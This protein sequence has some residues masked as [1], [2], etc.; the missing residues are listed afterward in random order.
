MTLRRSAGALAGALLL[1]AALPCRAG[2]AGP[3]PQDEVLR[4]LE[5]QDRRI[6]DL[7]RRL[8]ESESR[9][10]AAGAPSP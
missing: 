1:A 10:A 9:A 8:T 3:S 6:R 4:R 7:E 2:E 5:E